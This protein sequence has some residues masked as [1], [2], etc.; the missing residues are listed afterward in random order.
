MKAIYTLINENMSD[1]KK[2]LQYLRE[3]MPD[4]GLEE[5][6]FKEVR[7]FK[8]SLN[9]QHFQMNTI[10]DDFQFEKLKDYLDQL[11]KYVTENIKDEDVKKKALAKLEEFKANTA[12]IDE[13]LERLAAHVA[14]KE[15]L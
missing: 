7:F 13:S 9:T 15:E 1:E 2:R 3:F 10:L 11:S 5:H 4:T 12:N 6:H 8:T 14:S